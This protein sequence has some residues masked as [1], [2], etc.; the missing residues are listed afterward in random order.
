MILLENM[1]GGDTTKTRKE[2]N[3]QRRL[4]DDGTQKIHWGIWHIIWSATL[5]VMGVF[6]ESHVKY[7][8]L[9]RL[10]PIMGTTANHLISRGYV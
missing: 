10:R 4:L 7:V 3:V 9:R 6:L 1:T 2:K 5:Y 8:A